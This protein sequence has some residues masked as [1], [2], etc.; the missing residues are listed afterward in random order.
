MVYEPQEDSQLLAKHVARLAYG[1]VIDIGTGSGI[2]AK[3]AALSN[4]VTSVLATDID[5]KA[6]AQAKKV[7]AAIKSE[8]KMGVKV[9]AKVSDLF[10][11][12]KGKFDTIIFNPPYL[13]AEEGLDDPAL[14]G[15]RHGYETMNRFLG[16]VPDHLERDGQILAVY[17]S[18][19]HPEKVKERALNFLL[20]VEELDRQHVFFEDL[21]VVRFARSEIRK[22]LEQDGFQALE[23]FAKG[24]RG[25]VFKGRYGPKWAKPGKKPL[26]DVAIKITNPSSFSPNAIEREVAMLKRLNQHSIGPKFIKS[27]VGYAAMEFVDGVRI[28]DFLESSPAKK[29]KKVLKDILAECRALDKLGISKEEMTHPVKHILITKTCKPVMID[30]E[31]SRPSQNPSNVTQFCQFLTTSFTK[32][33]LA[34]KGIA[35][36]P[37]I[38][39]AISKEYKDAPSEKNFKKLEKAILD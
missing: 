13:P 9:S 21:L 36:D 29:I 12:V 38:L 31:R 34:S 26:K 5:P 4:K 23:Y 19:T 15:G 18:L 1:K 35:P 10:S 27:G 39:I 17:S 33:L 7:L 14:V 25:L 11:K 24:K 3:T 30:F 37:H 32:V 16:Q 22:T 6:V 28:Q 2:Q 8:N 20:T